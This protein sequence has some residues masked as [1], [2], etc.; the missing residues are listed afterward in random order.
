[1]TGAGLGFARK[2]GVEADALQR[3]ETPKGVYLAH[4]KFLRGKAAVDVLAAV[5][6]GALRDLQYPK[7]MRWD[8]ELDDGKGELLSGRPI[9]WVLFLYGGR[10]VPFE[11]LR[12]AAAASSLVQEVRS[13]A[14]TFGHRFLTTS[15]RAGRAIKVKGFDDYR[16]RLAENFVDPRTGRAP[17]PH[18]P[19]ARR[20]GAA[21]R[22]PGV[23]VALGPAGAAGG[24][25]PGRVP[26]GGV[27]QLR[28]RVPRPARRGAGDDDDSPPALLPAGVGP[29]RD[30]AGV[31]RRAQHGAR[32]TRAGGA[33]PRARA[34]RPAARRA[35]LLGGGSQPSARVASR[36]PVDGGVP[37]GP[38]DVPGQGRAGGAAG[39]V[40]CRRGVRRARRGRAARRGRPGCARRT[41]PRAWCA[42]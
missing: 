4:R 33:Q 17:R 12:T 9:R 37:Q 32:E 25:R 1:M 23:D 19:R 24:A 39:A 6:G 11:I 42:S 27:R 29:G 13:G 5:L 36:A 10:V 3:V 21:P 20:R 34:H 7:Q 16:R 28:R 30:D 8:A 14:V 38:G 40:D 31:S 35:L 41:W 2:Q 22:R 18:R 15:G 26:G